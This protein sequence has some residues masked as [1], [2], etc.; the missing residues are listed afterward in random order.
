MKKLNGGKNHSQALKDN[1][2]MGLLGALLPSIYQLNMNVVEHGGLE[3][4]LL[5][6]F[7]E[8]RHKR[9]AERRVFL[10]DY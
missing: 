9:R 1:R 4:P 3:C 8:C 7:F 2:W 5:N 6:F 10:W